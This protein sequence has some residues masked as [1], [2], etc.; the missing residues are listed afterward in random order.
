MQSQSSRRGEET[1]PLYFDIH[2][3]IE[4]RT[5]APPQGWLQI[6]QEERNGKKI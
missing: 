5:G 1:A 2:Q 6:Y 4:I 3:N